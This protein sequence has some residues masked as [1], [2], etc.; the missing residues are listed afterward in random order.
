MSHT[1]PV[2][3]NRIRFLVKVRWG[4]IYD[5]QVVEALLWQIIN[6]RFPAEVPLGFSAKTPQ[7]NIPWVWALGNLVYLEQVIESSRF[8]RI[9]KVLKVPTRIERVRRLRCARLSRHIRERVF[10]ERALKCASSGH[11]AG[12]VKKN[13]QDKTKAIDVWE[14]ELNSDQIFFF[15]FNLTPADNYICLMDDFQCKK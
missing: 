6:N 5:S 10:R 15:F 14:A 11:F 9:W 1:F 3:V 7:N 8:R 12:C 4:D 2:Q 13:A